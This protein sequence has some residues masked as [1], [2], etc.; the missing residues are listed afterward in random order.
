MIFRFLSASVTDRLM[1]SGSCKNIDL[2]AKEA[3]QFKEILNKYFELINNCEN[4]AGGRVKYSKRLKM[5]NRKDIF[6]KN[7]TSKN[8]Y[9]R[10][11]SPPQSSVQ[12]LHVDYA[13]NQ[14]NGF[15]KYLTFYKEKFI[16]PYSSLFFGMGKYNN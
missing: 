8:Y 3:I 15:Q 1:N 11:L 14:L 12:D 10:I 2:P 7:K 6:V 13:T 4:K 9:W 16:T 5:L